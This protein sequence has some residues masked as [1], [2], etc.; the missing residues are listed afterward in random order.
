MINT[1]ILCP[2]CLK[3]HL[4]KKD[5]EATLCTCDHCG[6]EFIQTGKMSVRYATANDL[7]PPATAGKDG[8]VMYNG[9][10]CS[11]HSFTSRKRYKPTDEELKRIKALPLLK[12]NALPDA[13]DGSKYEWVEIGDTKYGRYMY[14]MKTDQRRMPTMGEFYQTSPVD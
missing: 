14:C 1:Q 8:G 5:A 4:Q 12:E 10:R 2:D 6:T 3:G 9:N 11:I 7:T 13:D